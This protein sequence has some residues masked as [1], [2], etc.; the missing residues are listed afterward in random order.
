M[1]PV[2][3]VGRGMY[4]IGIDL[5]GTKIA[6][7]LCNESGEIIW[8]TEV[9]TQATAGPQAVMA[10]M[11]A[12]AR[13]AQQQAGQDKIVGI[14][15]GAPGPL[16]PK[17]G[18]V[19]APPNLPGWDEIYLVNDFERVMGLP[20][21]LEN[22][23]NA[24]ALAEWFLG[25]GC[26]VDNMFYIT[27]STGIGS[28][29]VVDGKVRHGTTGAFAELGH[30]V[31]DM[32]GPRCNCGNHGCLEAFASG[33]AIS[34]MAREQLGVDWGAD[35]LA[36]AAER[37][38]SKAQSILEQAYHALGIGIMNVVNLFD[39]SIIVVGGGVSR[40]GDPL[41]RALNRAVHENRF[42]PASNIPVVPA[43]LGTDAGVIGAAL[44]PFKEERDSR[45]LAFTV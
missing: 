22:D 31:I 15:I 1:E 18:I 26:K 16:N 39:P 19:A 45:N 43:R 20:T 6:T 21:H 5:G 24:A 33:T 27:V 40:I 30:M 13:E 9:S 28:G 17:T 42:R 14:G 36:A 25:A 2:T 35:Q 38:N 3:K 37:G 11:V 29:A 4:S 12:S 34:R 44:L 41:F 32:N 8:R 7:A 10:R 23:A